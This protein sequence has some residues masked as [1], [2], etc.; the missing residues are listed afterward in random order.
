MAATTPAGPGDDDDPQAAQDRPVPDEDGPH[1]V[2][3]D[4][5]IEKTLPSG[6]D[7]G[8]LRDERP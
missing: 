4:T 2:P 6:R 8:S 3:N 5:V 7:D 1:D